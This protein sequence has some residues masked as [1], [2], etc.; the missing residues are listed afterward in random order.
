M[1]YID[2]GDDR[3]GRSGVWLIS[4]C[5]KSGQPPRITSSLKETFIKR[6]IVEKTIKAEI[7]PEEQS[8]KAELSGEFMEWNTVERAIKTEMVTRTE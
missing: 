4:W 3:C 6:Y 2:G 7:R 5:F 8:E 1:T